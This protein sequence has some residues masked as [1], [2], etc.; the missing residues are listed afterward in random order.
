MRGLGALTPAQWKIC[1]E[2]DFPEF[3]Y[4]Q[5][6]VDEKPVNTYF[7]YYFM[8]IYCIFTIKKTREKKFF[9]IVEQHGTDFH[10]ANL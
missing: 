1:I 10:N 8:F 5:L 2:L 3:N 6:V 9:L 4:E 7:M